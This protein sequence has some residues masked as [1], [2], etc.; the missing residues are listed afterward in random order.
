MFAR[1]NRLQTDELDN[2]LNR[3]KLL[4]VLGSV[5]AI[6][7]ISIYFYNFHGGYSD[8]PEV[9]GQLGDF[10][11]GMLNPVF[12]FLAFIALLATF[13]IQIKEFRNSTE[14]LSKSAFALAQ[15]NSTLAKQNFENSFFQLLKLHNDIVN[16]TD[17]VSKRTNFVTKGRDCFKIFLERLNDE[18]YEGNAKANYDNFLKVY[19]IFYMNHESELGHY[20]RLL[21]N[22]VKLVHNTENIDKRFYT[23]IVRAQLSSAEIMLI[24]YNCISLN[25]REKFKPLVEEYSLL[26]TMPRTVL[27]NEIYLQQYDLKAF[28]GSY[29]NSYI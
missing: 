5:I 1:I 13:S 16:S 18:I 26:K 3:L 8:Q 12:S 23:N 24:F 6:F 22:I 9:W 2:L 21:Y 4:A 14:E 7:I 28:G 15:Q 11:G 19:E 17:L 20:F 10:F 27:P 29:P 25:G